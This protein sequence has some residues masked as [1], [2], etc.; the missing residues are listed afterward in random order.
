MIHGNR[1]TDAPAAPSPVPEMELLGSQLYATGAALTS[2]ADQLE[3]T[4]ARFL[5]ESDAKS[6]SKLQEAE[7]A[8]GTL[9]SLKFAARRL[10][11]ASERLTG[12]G[13]KV[14]SII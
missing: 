1:V 13:Y 3:T 4:L 6:P 7:P 9:A 14:A 12:L 8:P 11:T 5:G 10:E 2:L